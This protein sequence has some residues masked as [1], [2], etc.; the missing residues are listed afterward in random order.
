MTYTVTVWD[1]R[2][3]YAQQEVSVAVEGRAVPAAAVSAKETALS[4]ALQQA[5]KQ[6][7]PNAPIFSKAVLQ[8]ITDLTSTMQAKKVCA[9]EGLQ[10]GGGMCV[11]RG[12]A[13]DASRGMAGG[14][15]SGRAVSAGQGV[16]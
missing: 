6:G 4:Q 12:R 14:L 11:C 7:T 1:Q 8:G 2:G 16:R 13:G 9:R 15:C 3:G 10:V 5:Q